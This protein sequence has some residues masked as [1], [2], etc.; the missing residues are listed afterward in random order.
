MR[1][2]N[3]AGWLLLGLLPMFAFVWMTL[4]QHHALAIASPADVDQVSTEL[5][6]SM[7][8]GFVEQPAEASHTNTTTR[9]DGVHTLSVI[10]R[11]DGL[12]KTTG[13]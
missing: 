10:S 7:A 1:H 6:R 11:Q 2:N 3:L 13:L 12:G 4:S 8:F 9:A 5:A